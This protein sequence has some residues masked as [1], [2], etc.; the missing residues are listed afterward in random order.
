MHC[1][2]HCCILSCFASFWIIFGLVFVSIGF[3]IPDP[4]FQAIWTPISIIPIMIGCC[5]FYWVKRHCH[6]MSYVDAPNTPNVDTIQTHSAQQVKYLFIIHQNYKVE[7]FFTKS[8]MNA[9]LIVP[10]LFQE[11]ASH[12][13]GPNNISG[14]SNYISTDLTGYFQQDLSNGYLCPTDLFVSIY[15]YQKI[16]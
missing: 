14:S 10:F 11:H 9:Q 13:S 4:T 12:P 6:V 8:K 5:I 3:L 16:L 1:S 2:C 15:F 7:N